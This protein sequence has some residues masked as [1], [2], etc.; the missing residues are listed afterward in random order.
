MCRGM[1]RHPIPA[2]GPP[3]RPSGEGRLAGGRVAVFASRPAPVVRESHEPESRERN[4]E[5]LAFQ[6]RPV[7]T[8]ETAFFFLPSRDWLH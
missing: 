2:N 8:E 1:V 6:E 3:N 7:R 4:P 5:A